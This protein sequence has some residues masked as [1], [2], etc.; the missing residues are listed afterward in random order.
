MYTHS[1]VGS[2]ES[3][4][5]GHSRRGGRV[6]VEGVDIGQQ[7]AHH[8]RHSRTQVL[9]GQA[10]E[11]GHGLVNGLDTETH[12]ELFNQLLG[13]VVEIDFPTVVAFGE[14]GDGQFHPSV[15]HLFR[16]VMEQILVQASVL[17]VI[18]CNLPMPQK[19]D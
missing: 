12:G 5:S 11:V 3:I 18:R 17:H 15:V 16:Q 4:G 6:S 9:G 2:G 8:S 19:V 7:G 1:K 10:M 14:A 13:R